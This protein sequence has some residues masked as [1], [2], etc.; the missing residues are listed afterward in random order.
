[1]T[2]LPCVVAA[3]PDNSTRSRLN[4]SCFIASNPATSRF[5]TETVPLQSQSIPATR[6]VNAIDTS[7]L[8]SP[9]ISALDKK[10][11][12]TDFNRSSFQFEARTTTYFAG[13][14]VDE[15]SLSA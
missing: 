3:R 10:R 13:A 4:R 2:I 9:P 1:M 5:P 15:G 8:N 11:G 14:V 7:A 12:N 6:E